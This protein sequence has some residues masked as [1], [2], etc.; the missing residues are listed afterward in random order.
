MHVGEAARVGSVKE[1]STPKGKKPRAVN[2]AEE[3]VDDNLPCVISEFA[4]GEAKRPT[5]VLPN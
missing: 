3:R 4:E 2:F 5:G 1:A